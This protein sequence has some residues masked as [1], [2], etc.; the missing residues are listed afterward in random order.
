[1][2]QSEAAIDVMRGGK[3]LTCILAEETY[4]IHILQVREILRMMPLTIVPNTPPFIKGVCNLRGKIIPIIDLRIKLRMTTQD[5]DRNTCIVIVEVEGEQGKKILLGVIVDSVCDVQE[6]TSK[7]IEP[8]PQF[9]VKVDTIF[10][11]GMVR[12]K[13]GVTLL[14]NIDKV[15]SHEELTMTESSAGL[16]GLHEIVPEN[17]PG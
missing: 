2:S 11:Y 8:V 6:I 15:L 3:Y 14:M 13:T 17:Q 16:S 4:G 10:L 9:G 12:S 5:F 7:E 1:M